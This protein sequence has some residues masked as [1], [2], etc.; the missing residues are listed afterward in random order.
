MSFNLLKLLDPNLFKETNLDRLNLA[1]NP[2]QT[3]KNAFLVSNTLEILDLSKCNL[4]NLSN[5]FFRNLTA[6][7]KLNLSNNTFGDVSRSYSKID[8]L[9]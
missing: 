1:N 3:T 6:I 9:T 4:T 8:I 5:D 7:T 2:L